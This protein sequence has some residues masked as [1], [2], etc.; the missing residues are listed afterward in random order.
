MREWPRAKEQFLRATALDPTDAGSYLEL[1]K[2][3]K[4]AHD[5]PGAKAVLLEALKHCTE[6][7]ALFYEYALVLVAEGRIEEA[8][9]QLEHTRTLAPERAEVYEKLSYAYSRLGSQQMALAALEEGLNR[10][11]GNASL[12]LLRGSLYIYSGDPVS[13]GKFLGQAR[14]LKAPA[15]DLADFVEKFQ[16]RFG[17][18][19]VH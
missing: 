7:P 4:A 5:L 10:A 19:P 13:A 15:A 11:P 9:V 3:F 12:V 6:S 1:E 16:S 14:R 17:F 18:T 8:V 2:I